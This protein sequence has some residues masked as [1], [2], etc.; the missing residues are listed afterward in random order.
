MRNNPLSAASINRYIPFLQSRGVTVLF[1][2]SKPAVEEK[3]RDIPPAMMEPIGGEGRGADDYI[4]RRQMEEKED[5][6]SPK[7]N[8]PTK[9]EM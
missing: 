2:A 3:E 9:A 7:S 5:V 1:G 8:L 4:Y 6:I